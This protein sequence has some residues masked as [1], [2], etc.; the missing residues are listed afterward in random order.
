MAKKRKTSLGSGR[1]YH[2]KG[3]RT[4]FRDAHALL[5]LSIQAANE[6]KCVNALENLVVGSRDYA[7]FFTEFKHAVGTNRYDFSVMSA[8]KQR[9][10]LRSLS[11]DAI[12]A[13]QKKCLR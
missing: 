1:I 10:I 4:A 2:A 13:V 8:P 11:G 12:A 9:A 7:R 3:A 6:G 5:T